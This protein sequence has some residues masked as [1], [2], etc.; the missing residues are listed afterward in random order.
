[1]FNKKEILSVIIIV[2]VLAFA[3]TLHNLTNFL[4]VLLI[5]F[6]V[7]LI[8]IIA[9]KVSSFYLDSEIEVGIW[10]FQRYWFKPEHHFKKPVPAGAFLPIISKI[11]FLPLKNFVWMAS[12][13]FNVKPKTYRAARRHGLYTFSEMTED[14][15]GLIAASGIAANLIF[16][17]LGY[18]IGFPLFS[19]LN[20][21]YAFFNILPISDLDGN[22]IFFGNIILWSFLASLVFVGLFF[23]IFII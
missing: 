15:I 13:V 20:I 5:V 19:K 4:T 9:K 22:K 1:M 8:N 12:L 6:L 16:A 11:I 14:H 3:V 17:V 7:V 21:F 10:E 18:L 2:F 23:T